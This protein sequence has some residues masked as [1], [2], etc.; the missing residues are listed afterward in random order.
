VRLDLNPDGQCNFDCIY[1]EVRR[2]QLPKLAAP[3][4]PQMIRELEGV[5]DQIRTGHAASLPGCEEAPPEYLRLGHVALS[6]S[7]EPTLS[8]KFTEAVE[9]V[10]HL[11]AQGE[12]GFFKIA[13]VT[14][15]SRLNDPEV[16]R[17]LR[18][19]TSRDEVWAKL[20]A[21]S[22]EWFE[23][24]NRT[25]VSLD[26]ILANILNLARERPVVIQTLVP[27]MPGG[28][29][30]PEA[31]AAYVQRLIE[32]KQGGARISLVQ[33]YSVSRPPA[34]PG[35]THAPLSELSTIARMVREAT[36]FP[37]EVF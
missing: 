19:L 31:R 5:L 4:I 14:N 11:R 34:Q 21:G 26:C 7:G 36:G 18:L 23:R 25:E 1:C 24:I 27:L 32:L 13:V 29:P 37:A 20:D 28:P 8:P 10:L 16:C 9:A 2:T 35:C 17:G 22:P 12:H 3:E 6:G 15:A 30:P 33:L